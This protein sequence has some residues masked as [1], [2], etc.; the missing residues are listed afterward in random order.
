MKVSRGIEVFV[1]VGIEEAIEQQR[2]RFNNRN[3]I[4][5]A[6]VEELSRR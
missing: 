2:V 1:E 6:G 4:D 3:S 5:P